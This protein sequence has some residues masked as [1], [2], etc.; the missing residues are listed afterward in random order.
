MK[1]LLICICIVAAYS[2]LFSQEREKEYVF[3]TFGEDYGVYDPDVVVYEQDSSGYTWIGTADGLYRYDG[4]YFDIFNHIESDSLSLVDNMVHSLH[5]DSID[6]VLWI[7]TF[8]GEICKLNLETYKFHK[9]P[10]TPIQ[11]RFHREGIISS[12][13]RV[14]K[15]WLMFGT[16]NAGLYFY[17]IKSGEYINSI[18]YKYQFE[19]VPQIHRRNDQFWLCTSSGIYVCEKTNQDDLSFSIA[20]LEGLSTEYDIKSISFD[21]DYLTFCTD[22]SLSRFSYR[23]KEVEQLFKSQPKFSLSGHVKDD[24]GQYWVGTRGGGIFLID[25]EGQDKCNYLADPERPTQLYS[26]WINSLY[27]SDNQHVLWIASKG[28]LSML[29]KNQLKFRKHVV[30]K[31]NGWDSD[32]IYFVFKDSEGYYWYWTVNGFYRSSDKGEYANF[33]S[34]NGHRSI[35]QRIWDA[36]ED[37]N[38]NLWLASGTGLIKVNLLSLKMTEFD[39]TYDECNVD[40][41]NCITSISEVNDSTVWLSTKAALIKY[42]IKDQTY[43]INPFPKE[44]CE[45][46]IVNANKFSFI[47]DSTILIGVNGSYVLKYNFINKKYVKISSSLSTGGHLNYNSVLDVLTDKKGRVWLATYG[48]G[49]LKF[50]LEKDL[51][52]SASNNSFLTNNVYGLYED[53]KGYIWMTTN[54][55]I[56]RY[57]PEKSEASIYSKYEGTYCRE[58]NEGALSKSRDGQLLFGGVGGFVEFNPNKFNYNKNVPK[59]LISSFTTESIK[60]KAQDFTYINVEYN[61]PD[62]IIISTDENHIDFYSSVFNYSVSYKNMVAWKLDG[63]DAQWDTLMAYDVKSFA[64]LPEGSYQLKLRGCNN[65]Q[66]WND[67]EHSIKIIVKPTFYESRLFKLILLLLSILSF[68]LLYTLRVSVLK[69]RGVKLQFLI[70]QSTRKLKKTND[71]LEQSRE[72]ILVQKTEL[73]RHRNYLEELVLERTADL[74]MAREKAEESDRLKTAFLANVSHEIRTPMNSIVGFSSLLGLNKHDEDE[75]QNFVDLIQQSSESLLVLINDIIDISR[76]ESGQLQLVKKHIKLSEIC[77][78]VYQSLNVDRNENSNAK[79][80]LDLNDINDD[81]MIYTDWERLKQVLFNLLNNGLKFT[82]KGHVKLVVKKYDREESRLNKELFGERKMPVQFYL[83]SVEDTGIGIEEADHK[84]IFLPFIKVENTQMN[85][86]G[87]GLGLS[88]VKQIVQL[89][90]GDIWLKSSKGEGSTFYFYLPDY[91]LK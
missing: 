65:D 39:F 43:Q 26:S 45:D 7:G 67:Q 38:K 19:S 75:R 32:N 87:I 24:E 47:S 16:Y 71:E 56:V 34:S 48:S 21:K 30:K 41:L 52:E 57:D 66:V 22:Q 4:Q 84:S 10:N 42:N 72:E 88:I 79:L 73:E 69:R 12:I 6:N 51:I 20:P 50:D 15:E 90:G 27:F 31:L 76:I 78:T 64:R 17:N 35:S 60:N 13:Q 46:G 2:N 37:D 86:G 62:T 59:V 9:L 70:E 81:E 40:G 91:D 58:F 44:I 89:L 85:F 18:E 14:D 54:A 82:E 74:E 63:Y 55:N 33:K 1:K 77:N 80:E 8:F 23:S 25:S 36:Y 49:L 68:Y 11:G 29:D 83:F 61:V 28:G 53:A 5:Y 3:Q